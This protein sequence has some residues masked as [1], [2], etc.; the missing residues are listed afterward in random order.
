[1][2]GA[3]LIIWVGFNGNCLKVTNNLNVSGH[4]GA[5]EESLRHRVTRAQLRCWPDRSSSNGFFQ[6][7]SSVRASPS[8]LNV[9]SRALIHWDYI[10]YSVTC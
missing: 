8:Q 5:R 10:L 3:S 7:F 9:T 6:V 2:D 1:M 4:T